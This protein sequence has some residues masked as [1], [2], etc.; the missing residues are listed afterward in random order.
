[1]LGEFFSETVELSGAE[2]SMVCDKSED[3]I[4]KPFGKVTI[5]TP[6]ELLTR[7]DDYDFL[8]IAH[9]LRFE[10]IEEEAVSMGIPKEKIVLPFEV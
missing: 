3:K 9:H 8:M 10:E 2:V 4:G 1:M 6:G 5:C 7:T